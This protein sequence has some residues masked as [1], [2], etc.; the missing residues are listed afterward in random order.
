MVKWFKRSIGWGLLLYMREATLLRNHVKL[1]EHQVEL[2]KKAYM[3]LEDIVMK[4]NAE[5]MEYLRNCI[6]R[7]R[8]ANPR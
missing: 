1:L 3:S 8:A 5:G 7:L 4:A 6:E 2:H